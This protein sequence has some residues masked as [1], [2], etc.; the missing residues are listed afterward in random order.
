MIRASARLVR[1][2]KGFNWRLSAAEVNSQSLF[3]SI[4]TNF[5]S[6]D[7]RSYAKEQPKVS[8][9]VPVPFHL[10]KAFMN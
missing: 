1:S 10:S 9:A 8:K 7:L 2:T 5:S 4:R 3:V 6:K